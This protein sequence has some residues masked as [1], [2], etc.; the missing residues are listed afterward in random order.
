VHPAHEP[1]LRYRMVDG[2]HRVLKGLLRLR[3]A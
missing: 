1:P 2:V 3:R